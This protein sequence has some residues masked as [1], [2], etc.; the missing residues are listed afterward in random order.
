[1]FVWAE[2]LRLLVTIPHED[3]RSPMGLFILG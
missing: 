1:M 2:F 3:G